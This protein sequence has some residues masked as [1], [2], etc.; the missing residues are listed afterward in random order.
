MLC[1]PVRTVVFGNTPVNG[2]CGSVTITFVNSGEKPLRITSAAFAGTNGFV[3]ES[4]PRMPMVVQAASTLRVTITFAPSRTGL[5]RD[6][7]TL[8]TDDAGH[9]PVRIEVKG[10]GVNK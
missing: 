4:L 2:S 1:A 9:P 7:L 3:M 10:R 6:T 8:V 5:V